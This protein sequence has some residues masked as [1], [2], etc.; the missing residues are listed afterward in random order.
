MGTRSAL[1]PGLGRGR[2]A[3]QDRPG[4]GCGDLGRGPAAVSRTQRPPRG[5]LSHLLLQPVARRIGGRRG[6]AVRGDRGDG[7][8]H[9][10][11]SSRHAA[12]SRVRALDRA[13]R[14]R[15]QPGG[16]ECLG[17][18]AR[19]H[20]GRCPRSVPEIGRGITTTSSVCLLDRSPRVWPT[21][22]L[23]NRSGAGQMRWLRSTGRRRRSSPT[24]ATSSAPHLP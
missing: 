13:D 11:A 5:D 17:A 1:R 2:A 15:C 18:K 21:S 24:S 20:A 8:R 19:R 12:P 10:R 16:R 22:T 9:R 23:T 14:G 3:H 6:H 4:D 7:T